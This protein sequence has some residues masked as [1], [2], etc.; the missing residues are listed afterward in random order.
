MEFIFTPELIEKAR[1]AK[2]AEEILAL[3]KEHG[4]EMSE[5]AAEAHFE[6]LSGSGEM[7]DE[8]LDNVSGGGCDRFAVCPS[9]EY[10]LDKINGEW[11]CRSCGKRY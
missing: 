10:P 6:K 8:E 5:E 2:S 7:S 4:I 1:Q 9:C 11:V 3:A